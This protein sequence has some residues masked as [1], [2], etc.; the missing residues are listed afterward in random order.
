MIACEGTRK[1][2][3]YAPTCGANKAKINAQISN[4]IATHMAA[5]DSIPGIRSFFFNTIGFLRMMMHI[6]RFNTAS[7]MRLPTYT[8]T[9]VRSES[10]VWV[11]ML[12]AT[13]K[14]MMAPIQKKLR[15]SSVVVKY[16]TC[17]NILSCIVQNKA[18][19][20]KEN[21]NAAIFFSSF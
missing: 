14:N 16:S 4:K 10:G 3:Q 15:K 1:N 11:K 8:T 20:K 19:A 6:T 7:V 21:I 12:V 2:K 13:G 5:S 17:L 18:A 9:L